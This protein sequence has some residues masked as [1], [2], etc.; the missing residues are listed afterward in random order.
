MNERS[1]G[2]RRLD[3]PEEKQSCSPRAKLAIRFAEK[4]ALDHRSIDD[5]FF[6]ELRASFSDAEIVL[7]KGP[8]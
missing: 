6:V 4:R 7:A 1:C 8:R 3:L 2:T 5:D